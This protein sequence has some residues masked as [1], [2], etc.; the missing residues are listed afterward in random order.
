MRSPTSR[1][2]KIGGE[3]GREEVDQRG[4]E[5]RERDGGKD[6][7]GRFDLGRLGYINKKKMLIYKYLPWLFRNKISY[8]YLPLFS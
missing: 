4:S 5:M 7:D 3:R 8:I 1:S 2:R 6:P